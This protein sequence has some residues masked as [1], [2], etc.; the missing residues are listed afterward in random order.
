M[1]GF[2]EM[3]FSGGGRGMPG[4]GV[5]LAAEWIQQPYFVESDYLTM[6]SGLSPAGYIPSGR[7]NP[8]KFKS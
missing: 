8:P 7:T 4:V 5:R 6:Q 1:T 3:C 2:T